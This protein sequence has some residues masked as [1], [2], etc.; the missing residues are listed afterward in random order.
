MQGPVALTY[1]N[2]SSLS[3]TELAQVRREFERVLPVPGVNPPSA[4]ARITISENASEYLLVE[5]LRKGD[6]VEVWIAQWV[7]VGRPAAAA[8]EV[9]IEKRLVWEQQEQI[10]DVA[11]TGA[12]MLVLSPSAITLYARQ[13]SEWQPQQAVRLPISNSRPRDLRG[14]LRVN[15]QRVAAVLPGLAC[16]G[17]VDSTLAVEC[18]QSEEPWRLESGSTAILLANFYPGRNYFDGR[19]TL[20]NGTRKSVAP[21]YSAAA[22]EDQGANFWLLVMLD[23]RGHLFNA[24]LEELAVLPPWGSDIVGTSAKCNGRSQVFATGSSGPDDPDAVQAYSIVNHSAIPLG[25]PI[26]F[27]GS[28]TALWPSMPASTLAV[29]RDLATG[30]YAAYV[31]TVVCAP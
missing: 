11:F 5:E 8:P 14:R 13:G 23:G 20:Q 19:V 7:R 18:H 31:L 26:T 4:E 12:S 30:K 17:S 9:T 22:V 16:N 10:L 28:V 25:T 29:T 24:A 21:F 6:E 2:L 15:G 27:P 3:D 1:R